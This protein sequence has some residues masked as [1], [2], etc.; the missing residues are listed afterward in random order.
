MQVDLIFC[1][2]P[3]DNPDQRQSRVG[4]QVRSPYRCPG[5][6]STCVLSVLSHHVILSARLVNE[7]EHTPSQRLEERRLKVHNGN[8]PFQRQDHPL[9]PLRPNLRPVPV[10]VDV[11]RDRACLWILEWR[12]GRYDIWFWSM[13]RQ[14]ADEVL[15]SVRDNA[16]MQIPAYDCNVISF[17]TNPSSETHP[18]GTAWRSGALQHHEVPQPFQDSMTGMTCGLLEDGCAL[19]ILQV[20]H[21]GTP[22]VMS[23]NTHHHLDVR[24]GEHHHCNDTKVVSSDSYRV[25]P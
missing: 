14:R 6:A 25:K 2:N 16:V 3:M 20:R 1:W 19:R 24:V 15:V 9:A 7:E 17:P 4:L 21:K 23:G 12:R 13:E 10:W 5:S 18:C 22:S 8:I 11:N